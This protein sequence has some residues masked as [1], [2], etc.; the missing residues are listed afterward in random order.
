M[1]AEH[2]SDVRRR[3]LHKEKEGEDAHASGE[4]QEAETAYDWGVDD[5]GWT[6]DADEPETPAER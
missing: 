6:R 5:E 4:K 2:E 1:S 3:P